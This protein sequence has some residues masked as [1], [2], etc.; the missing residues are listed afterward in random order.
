[1]REAL[2]SNPL[3]Q[4]AAIGVLGVVVAFLLLTNLKGGDDPPPAAEAPAAS[5]TPSAAASTPA[6]ST[7]TPAPAPGTTAT[8]AEPVAPAQASGEFTAG[9]GL[10]AKIVKA[11]DRGAT[12]VLLITRVGGIDDAK[13]R[14]LSARLRKEGNI[15]L[16]HTFASKIADYSRIAQGV[17]VNRVPAVV[18]LAP[19][20]VSG[21]LPIAIVSYG[22]R[23]YDSLR[24]VARDVAYDGK[25]LPY[26]P[27]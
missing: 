27:K 1:M 26:H 15:A 16:F 13:L 23:G 8:P 7:T 19:R 10:P 4:M 22:F 9:P 25:R 21:D 14:T 12:V 5:G 3:V 24:Q 6:P 20:D 11:Y 18:A 17:D 2:N